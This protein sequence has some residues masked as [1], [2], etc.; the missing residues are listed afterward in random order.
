VWKFYGLDVKV[1]YGRC[2]LGF[3]VAE[4]VSCCGTF[5]EGPHVEC[6][7][8]LAT[9]YGMGLCVCVCGGGG[10]THLWRCVK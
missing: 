1:V 7:Q 4:N 10:G 6:L 3:V 5:V 8:N 9:A 2:K